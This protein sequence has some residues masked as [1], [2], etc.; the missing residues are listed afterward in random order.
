MQ[1]S[2]LSATKEN[3]SG[4]KINIMKRV[5]LIIVLSSVYVGLC[6][7]KT[8]TL[9]QQALESFLET[10]TEFQQERKQRVCNDTLIAGQEEIYLHSPDWEEKWWALKRI[11]GYVC[12]ESQEFLT[13][14]A[15]QDSS[16]EFRKLALQYLVWVDARQSVPLL[17]ER[18]KESLRPSERVRLGRVLIDLGDTTGYRLLE[19]ECYQ[20]AD[21]AL[22]E[23]CF[24]AYYL[25]P[26]KYAVPFYRYALRTVKT[27]G[28]KVACARQ[29]A[30]MGDCKTAMPVFKQYIGHE[31]ADVRGGVAFGLGLV[32]SK[33]SFRMLENM[34]ADTSF[35]VRDNAQQSIR[36]MEQFRQ[37]KGKR[38]WKRKASSASPTAMKSGANAY[39]PAAAV[40]Y[41]EKWCDSYNP[42][43]VNYSAQGGDCAAFLSQCLRAGGL[44]LSA[45]ADGYGLGVQRDKVIANVELMI[46]HLADVQGFEHVSMS[47]R[48]PEPALTVPG[49]PTLFFDAS[50]RHSLICVGE[51]E[52]HNLYDCHSATRTC[53]LS[54]DKWNQA[55][56]YYFH[57]GEDDYPEHCTNCTHDAALGEEDID[58]GGPCNPCEDAPET[59]TLSFLLPGK[60]EYKAQQLIQTR[61]N[62]RM[63]RG[64][65]EFMS[66]GEIVL[67]PGFSVEEGVT[68]SASI[69]PKTNLTRQ[70]RHVCMDFP[71]VITPNGDGWN[72][73]WMPGFVGCTHVKGLIRDL[74]NKNVC[75]IDEDITQDGV[76]SLWDGRRSGGDLLPNRSVCGFWLEVTDFKGEVHDVSGEISVLY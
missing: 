11:A 20:D 71:D 69:E 70:F 48:G 5:L 74:D 3:K 19:E 16:M 13:R 65:Y 73:T 24:N 32:E 37:S 46:R 52:G 42:E 51:E 4:I 35:P 58:C 10:K 8:E 53:H 55:V 44:D 66:G 26:P 38:L 23:D 30:M 29:L 63:K 61:N 43:Y 31:D 15:L 76:L 14:V 27:D 9:G 50:N 41:A 67:N 47:N 56:T 62:I 7:Q 64:H 25:M 2:Y 17:R 21:D 49:D 54:M 1:I 59:R 34:L 33:E 60:R 40:A 75:V 36:S 6:A 68:F 45:G 28:W 18:A 22:C 12:P 72:D 39:N 57:I